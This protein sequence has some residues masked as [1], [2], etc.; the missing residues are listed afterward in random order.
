MYDDKPPLLARRKEKKSQLTPD[1]Q[2]LASRLK[3]A[4]NGSETNGDNH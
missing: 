3:E 1:S 4:Y 2:K